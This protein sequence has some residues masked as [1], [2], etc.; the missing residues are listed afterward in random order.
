[1]RGRAIRTCSG[2]P[3]KVSN[4]WHLVCL[5]N[6]KEKKE[7]RRMGVENPELSEDYYTLERRM[8]GIL[9]LSYEGGY[10]ENGI[11]RLTIIRE[12]YSRSHIESINK[13]M[14]ARSARRHEVAREWKEA[15][16]LCDQMETAD[17]YQ[18]DE[19]VL[20]PGMVFIH[21][22]A[23]QLLTLAA[24]GINILSCLAE[25]GNLFEKPRFYIITAVFLLF[26]IFF[27]GKIL[28]FCT[29]MRFFR[30]IGKGVLKALR[31]DGQI[32]SEC[33]VMTEE[34][35]GLFFAAWLK[36]GTER[37]KS[38]FADSMEEMLSPVENQRYLLGQGKKGEFPKRY[39]CV[40]KVFSASREKAEFFQNSMEPFLGK[41]ELIYTRS[42]QGRKI[43]LQA[44][45]RAFANRNRRRA[46]RRKKIKSAL[47]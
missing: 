14:E 1:M 20:R 26:F 42:P 32:T 46:E 22:L 24:E 47:E 12:P 28:K 23:F 36:G 2:A 40:P 7:K 19:S 11:G 13:E 3:D 10:I 41:Y 9:G 6:P 29:P 31:E 15:I 27:G 44:R 33:I 21:A 25:T 4:I 34:E 35:E 43:L 18:T 45:A 17:Q 38:L 8:K 5:S 16:T 37:E 30:S 39:Y